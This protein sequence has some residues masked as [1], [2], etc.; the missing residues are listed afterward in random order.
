MAVPRNDLLKERLSPEGISPHSLLMKSIPWLLIVLVFPLGTVSARALEDSSFLHDYRTADSILL[1]DGAESAPLVVDPSDYPGVIRA[2]GNL[3]ADIARVSQATPELLADW[4]RR[5]SAIVVGTLGRSRFIDELVRAGKINVEEIRGRWEGYGLFAVSN[6]TPTL[7]YALVIVGSDKRG[8]IFG[9]YTLSEQLGVSPWYWWADVAPRQRTA[10]YAGSETR[11][12]DAPVVKFRG[13]FLNDEAPALAGWAKE[14]FGGFNRHFYERL[15]ELMLRMKANYL[16]PAMWSPSAF[17]EDDAAN[18]VLADEFGIVMGT[19]HHEPMLRSQQEWRRRGVGEWDYRAN[20]HGLQDFW[21]EG[22]RRNRNFESLVTLGMRGDGDRSI[23][24][25]RD[26]ELMEKVIADQRTILQREL[27]KPLS[28]IPQVW[29]LYKEVQ[30]YYDHGL[31][32]PDDV[33]LL[34]CDDNFGHLRRLPSVADRSRSGGAGI[35]YHFDYFGRPRSYMWLNTVPLA[36]IWTQMQRAYHAGADRIWIVNVGDLKPLEFPTEFFLTLAWSPQRWPLA[37]LQQ[38]ARLWAARE[39][40]AAQAD[41]VARLFMAYPAFNE[42]KKPEYLSPE[43]FSLTHYREAETVLQEWRSLVASAEKISAELPPAQRDAFFQL[44]SYPIK[45]SAIAHELHIT[46]GRNRLYAAQGRSA[47]NAQGQKARDLFRA[48]NELARAYNED[49]GNGKWRHIMDQPWIGFQTAGSTNGILSTEWRSP[50]RSTMPAVTE[51][52]VPAA[53]ELAVA[54]EGNPTAW[55]VVAPMNFTS[56]AGFEAKGIATLP[57]LAP[58]GA[59][60]R[61]LDVFNRGRTPFPYR[62]SASEPWVTVVPAA[63]EIQAEQRVEVQIDWAR[64]PEGNHTPTLTI[65]G[66]AGQSVVVRVPI[67]KPAAAAERAG[68]GFMEGDSYI[69]INAQ[70]FDL[71]QERERW[72]VLP[73]YGRSG[74]S[75]TAPPGSAPA[76]SIAESSPLEYPVTFASSGSVTVNL[77]VSPGLAVRG[78]PLRYAVAFDQAEPQVLTVP[79]DETTHYAGLID[80]VMRLKSTHKISDAGP[81]RLRIWL[82]DPEII[83]QKIVIETGAVRPSY[84]GPPPSDRLLEVRQ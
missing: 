16:W 52:D 69:S 14:K 49:L 33:T 53:A 77:D 59:G 10:I 73:F 20:A 35:Y 5:D 57:T 36:K 38:Y 65:E 2:A 1:V 78:K 29:A 6:P 8:T 75:V 15:F 11:I 23:P 25:G 24:G 67:L 70:D 7:A 80:S 81:R 71:P 19:S 22:I 17:N 3:R 54:V 18:P 48:G 43:T 72:Q 84:L 51:I 63:G 21:T 82:L 4:P 39:F 44:V 12:V 40:G 45:A 61:W 60:S 30:E 74:A 62:I 27:G 56:L 76:E 66:P 64:A 32:V 83:L 28:D 50:G 68:R 9:A 42:R 46:V 58:H 26:L 55:V 79:A 34:F 47:T 13:I 37:Q 41:E 31:V